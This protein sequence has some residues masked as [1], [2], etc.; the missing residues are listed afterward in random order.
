MEI[1][2]LKITEISRLLK[3]IDAEGKL[4]EWCH[5]DRFGTVQENVDRKSLGVVLE[6][7]EN[8]EDMQV[9]YYKILDILVEDKSKDSII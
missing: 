1:E 2:Y 4:H 6:K 8:M 7:I 3:E 9:I 5:T